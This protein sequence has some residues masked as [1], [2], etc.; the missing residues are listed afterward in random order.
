MIKIIPIFIVALSILGFICSTSTSGDDRKMC[1]D[2]LLDK[3]GYSSHLES[4]ENLRYERLIE[5]IKSNY[6]PNRLLKKNVKRVLKKVKNYLASCV[7]YNKK[8]ETEKKRM[9]VEYFKENNYTF[10]TAETN[11]SM[12]NKE[13]IWKRI[14]KLKVIDH[15]TVPI[16]IFF[17]KTARVKKAVEISFSYPISDLLNIDDSQA[18]NTTAINSIIDQ[19]AE[20]I[21]ILHAILGGNESRGQNIKMMA[22]IYLQII[23]IHIENPTYEDRSFTIPLKNASGILHIANLTQLVRDLAKAGK[24]TL[25][26]NTNITI[27]DRL[28]VELLNNFTANFSKSTEDLKDLHDFFILMYALKLAPSFLQEAQNVEKKLF[29]G[30]SHLDSD[31]NQKKCLNIILAFGDRML[32]FLFLLKQKNKFLNKIEAISKDLA[33]SYKKLALIDQKKL[34][35]LKFDSLPPFQEVFKQ[36]VG[37]TFI[38]NIIIMMKSKGTYIELNSGKDKIGIESF[39]NN[40]NSTISD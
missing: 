36:L 8:T 19:Y 38:E 9:F 39:L 14:T 22:T 18:G 6:E 34:K 13:E 30:Y 25:P 24:I 1:K 7:D 32:D 3:C 35:P 4:K 40:H 31:D 17:K 23:L 20:W 29:K 33:N 10:L 26:K 21:R 28:Y 5:I 2:V 37:K 11:S 16:S 12:L 15:T 27:K